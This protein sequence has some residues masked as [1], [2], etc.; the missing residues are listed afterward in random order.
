MLLSPIKLMSCTHW[1]KSPWYDLVCLCIYLPL[2]LITWKNKRRKERLTCARVAA[3]HTLV[4]GELSSII[5]TS[6][7][8]M[9]VKTLHPGFDLYN[10]KD[11]KCRKQALQEINHVLSWQLQETVHGHGIDYIYSFCIMKIA[12]P[13]NVLVHTTA[14]QTTV[15]P[16]NHCATPAESEFMT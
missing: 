9:L 13:Q 16:C 6:E 15:I 4:I 2:T 10:R 5:S 11:K 3:V 14:T 1:I 7:N 12:S 8:A